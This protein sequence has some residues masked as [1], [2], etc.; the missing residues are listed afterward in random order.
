[1]T[2][3]LIK[4]KFDRCA[5]KACIEWKFNLTLDE[6][7]EATFYIDE[8]GNF[9]FNDLKTQYKI[10][11]IVRIKYIFN[12]F[13][14]IE[15]NFVKLYFGDEDF[16]IIGF[17]YSCDYF[18]AYSGGKDFSEKEYIEFLENLALESK[19]NSENK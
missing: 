16:I 6:D 18:F 2:R 3:E 5:E 13:D 7:E 19:D 8:E 17:E 15:E 9:Y 1:M 14:G 4:E 10:D 12:D 11:D